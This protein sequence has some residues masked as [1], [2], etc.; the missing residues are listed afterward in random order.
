[1]HRLNHGLFNNTVIEGICCLGEVT[2][3]VELTE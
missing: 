2:I 1:M 3:T